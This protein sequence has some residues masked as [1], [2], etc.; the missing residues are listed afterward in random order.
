MGCCTAMIG[1]NVV[2]WWYIRQ[3]RNEFV[4]WSCACCA[5]RGSKTR[6]IFAFVVVSAAVNLNAYENQGKRLE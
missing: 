5:G 2:N 1:W 3:P 4:F 6:K